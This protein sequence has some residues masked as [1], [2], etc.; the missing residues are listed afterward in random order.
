M[1]RKVQ[2][3]L[4]GA[5]VL[6]GMSC[7]AAN[8][9]APAGT[10]EARAKDVQKPAAT[11][12]LTKIRSELVPE[13][14]LVLEASEAPAYTSYRP[15]GDVFVVDL[16]RVVKKADLA[17]PTNLPEFVA[18]LSAE[19]VIELGAPMTRVTLRF[20]ERVDSAVSM[21]NGKLI[22]RF[23]GSEASGIA[24]AGSVERERESPVVVEEIAGADILPPL[25]TEPAP[26]ATH[27]D[28]ARPVS[29]D[30]RPVPQHAATRLE[31]IEY[32]VEGGA[33]S[34]LLRTD[35]RTQHKSFVLDNPLRL[36]VDLDG[37]VNRVDR[38]TYTLSDPFVKKIR[39]AQFQSNPSPVA[40]VVLDL[41][42]LPGYELKRDADGLRIRFGGSGSA[43]SSAP[44]VTVM[45][46]GRAEPSQQASASPVS[47]S[48]PAVRANRRPADD[49]RAP[50]LEP[51]AAEHVV[52][53]PQE[54]V[55]EGGA[56]RSTVRHEPVDDVFGTRMVEAPLGGATMRAPGQSIAVGAGVLVYTGEP[57]DLS[58]TNADIVDVL[59]L[60][61]ELTGLN[62]AIDPGV[63]GTVTVDFTGVPW[64]QALDLIL[65]QN[66]LGYTLEGNVMRIGTLDRLAAETAK[67]RQLAEEERLNVPLNTMIKYLSYAKAADIQRILSAM[68]T[69]RG[70]IIVDPR[71]N[72]LIITE[73]PEN[74]QTMLALIETIDIPTPQVVIEARIVETTKTFGRR[75]GIIWGFTGN[76]DP[77]LGS[78]TGLAF[79][80]R[81]FVEGGPFDLSAGANPVLGVSLSNVLG[82][83][84]L[85]LVLT[86]AENE[87]L[88]KVVSAPKVTTQDNEQA[89]IQS[90]VQIPVQTRVNFTTTVTYIDAT[91]LLNVTPQVTAEGTVI[92]EIQVQ[93]TEPALGL[94]VAGAQNSPL[95][96]RRAQT[97]LMV[98]DGGTAVIGGIY[99]ATENDSQNRVPFIHEIPVLGNLFK[100]RAQT[101]RHDELLI[102]ITPRIVRNP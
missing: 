33:L 79:P 1:M 53:S 30:H 58:L 41:D 95:I 40:R 62:M 32:R 85:D 43:A 16:P 70:R 37:V 22:I 71:T 52:H 18:S 73:V 66:N 7:S 3:I 57:I 75:L 19:E 60:F 93:K 101:S 63:S 46:P 31:A 56:I 24:A 10:A 44:P 72:Q 102:F 49:L 78:G 76:A 67:R 84:D 28:F 36:V 26:V 80:N 69:P 39:V 88:V 12:T 14:R 20:T 50:S 2:Y 54:T 13:P 96:T 6:L 87:G 90:G 59:R 61:S 55:R 45:A 17:I 47:P 8:S 48:E 89:E 5:L 51:I 86:A 82:T 83:F 77:A 98:R 11:P 74:L 42:E 9:V 94:E 64:D 23:D 4:L 91:L 92:M 27:S 68:A 15:Q 25:R 99:Q 21:E 29:T 65:R 97:K 34:V 35:G 81:I 38:N 100:S